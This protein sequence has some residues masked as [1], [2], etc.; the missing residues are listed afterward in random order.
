[1]RFKVWPRWRLLDNGYEFGQEGTLRSGAGQA[2][3]QCFST[4]ARPLAPEDRGW[5]S[6]DELAGLL[7]GGCGSRSIFW[8]FCRWCQQSSLACEIK[9]YA[10]FIEGARSRQGAMRRY[11]QCRAGTSVLP[12]VLRHTTRYHHRQR[13]RRCGQGLLQIALKLEQR[14]IWVSLWQMQHAQMAG[15]KYW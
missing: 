4:I 1:M 5:Y 3:N 7:T 14:S 6:S 8:K 2:L 10:M 11:V 9:R 15:A 12:N 13:L